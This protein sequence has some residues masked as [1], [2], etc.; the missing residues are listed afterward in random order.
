MYATIQNFIDLLPSSVKVGDNN[1]G[2]PTPGS[3]AT[4]QA[5]F[6]QNQVIRFIKMAQQEI[7]SRLLAFYQV[8][9]RRTKIFETEIVSDAPA[10]TNVNV[11][12]HDSSVF[13]KYDVIRFQ[14]R[15]ITEVSTIYDIP[16]METLT[17]TSLKNTF[18][19]ADSALVSMLKFPDPIPL[20]AA[21]L[22]VSFGFDELY[23]GDQA[24][25]VSTYGT[26]QRQLANNAMDGILDGTIKLFGQELTGRRFIRGQ[27]FD[28]YRNPVKDFQFGREK[29]SASG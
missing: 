12:V 16:D 26:T 25:N 21:R 3:P 13:S 14:N 8:P 29:P 4:K 24:P 23:T 10:G 20:I 27:L 18:L 7:D 15:D 28:A 6:N 1:P 17:V 2:V 5:S 11:R 22:A 19:Q 9:L